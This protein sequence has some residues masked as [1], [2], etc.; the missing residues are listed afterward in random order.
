MQQWDDDNESFQILKHLFYTTCHDDEAEFHDT[1]GAPRMRPIGP[2]TER[3]WIVAVT[4][5]QWLG[6]NVGMC[7]VDNALKRVG[8]KIG[9]TTNDRPLTRR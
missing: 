4:I 9:T 7:F 6:S 8:K 2:P 5:I 1:L 3:D